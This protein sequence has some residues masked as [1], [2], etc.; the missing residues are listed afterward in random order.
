MRSKSPKT[1]T[2][3][4]W[5]MALVTLCALAGLASAQQPRQ[6]PQIKPPAP[7]GGEPNNTPTIL[8]S[9]DEDYRIGPRDVIEIR[10]DDAQELSLTTSV[11][12]NGTF[13]M[14][15]LNRMT[16]V[17][18]TPEELS[19]E[20]ADRLR[21]KYL[22]NPNVLV[23]VKQFYS[24]SFF[25]LGAVRKPGVYQ[26]EGKPSLLKLLT[27]AGGP[28]EN[29]GSTA[30]IMREIK[31]KQ[32]ATSEG[33][34]RLRQVSTAPQNPTPQPAELKTET[35]EE[36][37]YDTQ[38]VNINGLFRGITSGPQIR[39]EPG[40]IVNIPIADVFYVAGEV[41][42]PGQFELKEGTTL[43]Q[44]MA[45]AQGTTFN[46]AG[47]DGVIFRTDLA[48]GHR[49]EIKVNVGDV[50]KNKKPD[51]VLLANDIVMVPNSKTKTIG[52]AFLKA[53]G[54]GAAQRGPTRY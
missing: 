33:A 43:R 21:G 18:K 5:A 7:T 1:Q 38:V 12:A 8:V 36:P 37:D 29:H 3:F 20:I 27:I 39:L 16:A 17:G 25:I 31:K 30:L 46:A 47:G 41:N 24:R 11:N 53:L 15:Y 42:A 4:V 26:I 14:P 54:M 44:A 6:Q 49:D 50:M 32:A 45:L 2:V 40:D 28:A 35:E 48:T 22:K 51:I 52:N 23:I 10:V 13:L 19:N 9:P 34:T